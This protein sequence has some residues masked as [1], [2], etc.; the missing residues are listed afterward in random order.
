M[1]GKIGQTHPPTLVD[2]NR[3][4][5]SIE[6]AALRALLAGTPGSVDRADEAQAGFGLRR[7]FDRDLTLAKFAFGSGRFIG[8]AA[9]MAG[10]IA[11]RPEGTT[12]VVVPHPK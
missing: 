1:S 12:V 2:D 10:K 6:A 3:A 4:D 7:Q 9:T 8:H 5:R 11:R